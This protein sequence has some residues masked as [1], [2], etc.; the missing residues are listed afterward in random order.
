MSRPGG[1]SPPPVLVRLLIRVL[2]PEQE[3][4]FF[5][6]DLEESGRHSWL[7]EVLG[8]LALRLSLHPHPRKTL[9]PGGDGMLPDLLRDMRHGLRAMVRSPGFTVVALVTMALGIGA[10]T[11][12]FSIVNGV[13]L[14]SL[15][16]PDAD[17]IVYLRET[18][19]SRG[20]TSF[21]IAPLNL[22]DWQERN[23]SLDAL[24]SYQASSVNYTG[25]DRPQSLPVYRVSDGFLEILGGEAALGRG[26]T[27]EDLQ[28]SAQDVVL[29]TYGFWQRAFGGDV[30]VLG[31][32]M[33]LD[34]VAYT[35]VG[36]LPRDWQPI[37]RRS[38]DLIVPLKPQPF[39]YEARGSHFLYAV[40]H[41]APGVT[42]EQAR[43]DLTGIATSLEADYPDTN[44]GWG[45]SVR[46]LEDVLLGSTRPQL[47]IFMA[48][49]GLVLLI[50]CAN[51]ANMTLARAVVRTRELAIRTA[52]GAGRG[53]VVRQLLAESIVLACTGGALGVLMAYG[54]LAAFTAG[55]PTM[56]PRMQEI[57]VDAPVL[58]FSLGLS[59]AAGVL[60][61]LA[62]ALSVAGRGLGESLRQGGRGL[63]GDRSRRW[64]RATLVA[65]E[66]ALAVVLLVG[67]GLLLRSFAALQGEDPGFQREGRLVLSTPLPRAKY[68]TPDERR[69]FGDAVATRLNALPGVESASLTSLIPLAGSDEIWGFW[70]E[71]H[72]LTGGQEDGSAL[73]YRVGPGYLETMGIPLV[74]GRDIAPG[75]REDTPPV[76]VI[77]A[78]LAEQH[79][80][81]ENPIG[82]HIKFG[83]DDDEPLVQVVGVAGDVQHYTLGRTSVPQVYVPFTQRPT[84]N[85]NFVI[86]TSVP[87]SSLVPAVRETVSEV[88]PDQPVVGIEPAEAMIAST[89]SM[90][91]FRTIL[92]TAFGLTALLLAVVGL[93]GVL[94]YAVSQRTREIGVRMALGAS[95]GSVLGLVFRQGAPLVGIG[96]VAGIVGALALTRILESML[97]GVGTHDPVVFVAVPLVL[98]SVAAVAM[99]VPARRASRVDPMRTLAET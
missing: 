48:S 11:A 67:T 33:M 43:S 93:Y 35:A 15:P 64:M 40:G 49:V 56:L 81:G 12:M 26:I 27:A 24:G 41:L 72:A 1:G 54:A 58:L 65:G 83:R 92:M 62:P 5:L 23:R 42:V 8:A 28:P 75:D 91:R 25:G 71:G 85:V 87:P 17:R 69:G 14:K 4:E 99:L 61:G 68:A 82:K 74:A 77:S 3:R 45:V 52:M 18:N 10:N 13:I 32:T 55:W 51:L 86:A 16:Y 39:W 98:A 88:D 73:F 79:F 59:L 50:A 6:G 34:G 38:I 78:S 21:S 76:A 9:S 47:L 89:I 57:Q 80:A 66:V 46:P 94:A 70:V 44:T 63:A 36:I 97:F 90:P 20:W 30:G 84:G 31:R 53:R 96:L 37:S 60:F 22:W 7:R 29:L 95:R 2:L 19:L